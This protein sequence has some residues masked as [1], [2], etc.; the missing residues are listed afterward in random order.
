MR[1]DLLDFKWE[2][3]DGRHR[4]YNPAVIARHEVLSMQCINQRNTLYPMRILC[5]Q[6]VVRFLLMRPARLIP[7][8]Q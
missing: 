2:V 1:H 4:N 3:L 6:C 7:L 5:F 8:L